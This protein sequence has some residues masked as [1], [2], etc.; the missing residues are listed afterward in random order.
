M[1]RT[2]LFLIETLYALEGERDEVKGMLMLSQD[3]SPPA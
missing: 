3:V 1:Y 2:L